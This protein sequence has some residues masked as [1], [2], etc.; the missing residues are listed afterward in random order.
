MLAS[1][2]SARKQSR[3]AVS[4][5]QRGKRVWRPP[6]GKELWAGSSFIVFPTISIINSP[7]WRLTGSWSG[8]QRM[9]RPMARNRKRR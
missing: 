2:F 1:E 8:Q 4:I 3:E 7:W 9:D 5:V 6:G